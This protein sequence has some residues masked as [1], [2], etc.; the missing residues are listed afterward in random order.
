LEGNSSGR[1][2]DV[3]GTV[4]AGGDLE[5]SESLKV[6]GTA[7]VGGKLNARSIRVGGRVEAEKVE[8]VEEIRT[9]TLKTKS[10]AMAGYIELGRRGEAEGPLIAKEV[11]VR[12]RGRVED[13]YAETVTL[14][15]DCR[16]GNIYAARIRLE[17]GCRIRGEVRYTESL[18][19]D[20]DVAFSSPPEKTEKLPSPPF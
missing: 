7:E 16:A 5:L 10:G 14:R 13:I 18:E 8:A 11:L 20:R 4:R 2:I 15:R 9:N 6:G 17:S 1:S 3:G 19:A 12:D